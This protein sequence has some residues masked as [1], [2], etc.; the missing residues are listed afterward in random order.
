MEKESAAGPKTGR[1]TEPT[2]PPPPPKEEDQVKPVVEEKV[3]KVEEAPAP[4]DS[5][6]HRLTALNLGV[7]IE[8]F[9]RR[10]FYKDDIFMALSKYS[11]PLG[12]APQLELDWFPGAHVSQGA[13]AR[14][15]ISFGFNYAVGITSVANDGTR[16]STS[17]MRLRAALMGRLTLGPLELLPHVGYRLQ[18]YSIANGATGAAKPNIPDVNYSTLR[19]GLG[20]KISL[21]GPLSVTG[22]FAYQAPL[23]T[24]EIGTAKYFPRLKAGGLDANVGIAIGP[25]VNHLEL[26]LSGDYV[27][28]WYS[29]NPEPGDAAI[30]GGATDDYFGGSLMIAFTL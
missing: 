15:G 3:E 17:A 26:R 25:L 12:P 9:S 14:I 22:G 6:G 1:K 2:K 18:S 30:A 23:S 5:E 10:F 29:M 16:Y 8:L 24:G 19:A 11:L 27:R 20:L 4:P 13:I 28:Y 21:V 7:G